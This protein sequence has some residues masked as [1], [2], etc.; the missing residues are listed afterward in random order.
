MLN[1]RGTIGLGFEV[2]GG[3]YSSKYK[4]YFSKSGCI[5]ALN[6]IVWALFVEI[7]FAKE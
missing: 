5:L 3:L 2:R 7:S 4:V 1:G 6:S